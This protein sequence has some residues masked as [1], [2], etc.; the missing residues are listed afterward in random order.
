MKQALFFGHCGLSE[1]SLQNMVNSILDILEFKKDL[2]ELDYIEFN[3]YN[4]DLMI[5]IKFTNSIE[6]RGCYDKWFYG[7]TL[8]INGNMKY[9]KNYIE[10][11]KQHLIAGVISKYINSPVRNCRIEY[12]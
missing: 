12:Y 4:T 5:T 6:L 3:T 1:E 2:C 9:I 7:I 8:N 11:D 10:K